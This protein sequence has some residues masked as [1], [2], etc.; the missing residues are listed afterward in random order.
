MRVFITVLVL[1]FS[2]Q[3]WTKADDVR[4]FEFDGMSIG[5]SLLD[6]FS[7]EEIIKSKQATQYPGSDKYIV[8]IVGATKY[9][10]LKTLEVYERLNVT[11]NKDFVIH[12]ITGA[13]YFK[14][15]IRDCKKFQKKVDEELHNLFNNLKKKQHNKLKHPYDKSGKSISDI[16]EYIFKNKDRITLTCLDWAKDME[17]NDHFS[18]SAFTSIFN[19]WL[20]N[21]AY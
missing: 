6:Y 4:D 14:E 21:E 1:I 10:G 16:I 5:D 19:D 8:I 17:R 7:E 12:N 2:F 18:L 20:N 11:I 9:E 3:S 13:I 15:N